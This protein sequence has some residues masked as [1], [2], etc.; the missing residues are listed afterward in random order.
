R[1]LRSALARL[2]S[3]GD[4][5]APALARALGL[6]EL[7]VG[8]PLGEAGPTVDAEG[9]PTEFEHPPVRIVR[10]GEPVALVSSPAAAPHRAPLEAA[11]GPRRGS[12]SPTSASRPNSS[13]DCTS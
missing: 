1:L 6:S 2:A 11:L 13:S 12:R 5:L 8:Y 4:G 3:A 9:R 7:R 10:A